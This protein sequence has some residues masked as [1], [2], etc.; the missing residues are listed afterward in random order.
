VV[1]TTQ[2]RTDIA[3]TAH[4]EIKTYSVDRVFG[5][6]ADQS[7]IFDEIIA[8]I[9]DDMLQGINCTVFAYG[10]TGTGKT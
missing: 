3:V 8:P 4:G 10:Q 7:L 1:D 6:E 9:V 5:P 2:S